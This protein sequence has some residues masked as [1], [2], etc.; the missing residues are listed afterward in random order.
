MAIPIGQPRNFRGGRT[1]YWTGKSWSSTKPNT[2]PN[3]KQNTK[4]KTNTGSS[5]TTK[6]PKNVRGSGAKN[7]TAQN[8][9]SDKV[10]RAIANTAKNAVKGV[11]QAPGR[12][13]RNT[14]KVNQGV[15]Q[16]KEGKRGE[17]VN[18]EARPIGSGR[19]S[20]GKKWA[21]QSMGYQS[22]ESFNQLKDQGQFRAGEIGGS[23]ILSDIGQGI[24]GF[25]RGG[26]EDLLISAITKGMEAYGNAPKPVQQGLNQVGKG[27]QWVDNR[28]EDVSRATNTSRLITDEAV[29]LGAGKALK[30]GGKAVQ[31]GVKSSK[32]A[33][34]TA[35]DK[36]LKAISDV[37]TKPGPGLTSR[38]YRPA[39]MQIKQ[40]KRKGLIKDP[41]GGKNPTKF[42]YANNPNVGSAIPPSM[43]R[44]EAVDG[45][46]YVSQGTP[47]V[48]G[49]FR[50]VGAAG[51]PSNPNSAAAR[52]DAVAGPRIQGGRV[53]PTDRIR[54]Q[55]RSLTTGA[56]RRSDV[57]ARRNSPLAIQAR[58]STR[59]ESNDELIRL[60]EQGLADGMSSEDAARRAH[61]ISTSP[62]RSIPAAERRRMI[63]DGDADDVLGPRVPGNNQNVATDEASRL[64]APR[65]SR[66]GTVRRSDVL[67]G[68]NQPSP[69]RPAGFTA[70][71]ERQAQKARQVRTRLNNMTPGERRRTIE[72]A[73]P[74]LGENATGSRGR[75]LTEPRRGY[76]TGIEGEENA[77]ELPEQLRTARTNQDRFIP[78]REL[79]NRSRR[80][81]R[82]TAIEAREAKEAEAARLRERN[83]QEELAIYRR[84]DQERI[85]SRNRLAG[86]E[87]RQEL[88]VD[89]VRQQP[90][91]EQAA[92]A[93]VNRADRA[94]RNSRVARGRN[95]RNG[96]SLRMNNANRRN[97]MI[98]E[99]PTIR[100]QR[101]GTSR[102]R[103]GS[104]V[105]ATQLDK[106]VDFA[107]SAKRR[108]KIKEVKGQLKR[109]TAKQRGEEL[110]VNK[111]TDMTRRGPINPETGKRERLFTPENRAKALRKKGKEVRDMED[112]DFHEYAEGRYVSAGGKT[113]YQKN[114]SDTEFDQGFRSINED[115]EY[116]S[117]AELKARGIPVRN[118]SKVDQKL[119]MAN[120]GNQQ[121]AILSN[122]KKGEVVT[123]MPIPGSTMMKDGSI[124]VD[125][126]RAKLY[127][128]QTKGALDYLVIDEDTGHSIIK[129]TK[130]GPN[131]W[132]TVKGDIVEFDPEALGA[133]IDRLADKE[134]P[135]RL[136]G[137]RLKNGGGSRA[138][139]KIS[140]K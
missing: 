44:S 61:L 131:K 54:T 36:S 57:N 100:G 3:T 117:D 19:K 129:T 27:A 94:G 17:A 90:V 25:I 7:K 130:V 55:R 104:Y 45:R 118:K 23:R 72:R 123:A 66:P 22:P 101:S 51:A 5:T 92:R 79:Q 68:R 138:Q 71:Q 11:V 124:K 6:K 49:Q 43:R 52:F 88:A 126:Q 59:P 135:R 26:A 137:R 41:K 125:T 136:S 86:N 8:K 119:N 13:A 15:Q 122:M 58:Q 24:D 105:R 84:N 35:T 93:V 14:L 113:T 38:P 85:A 116:R 95:R 31:S 60:Y 103:N 89:R 115:F 65:Q 127:K 140:R 56:I 39:P 64:R 50:S 20:D 102:V 121:G 32:Q 99:R 106:G 139:L 9:P 34:K 28:L 78:N 2:K 81:R 80:S 18:A 114:N 10:N 112:S 98:E 46:Q 83:R 16:L 111:S 47:L 63:R 69:E 1:K 70:G 53:D 4:P 21:G 76:F 133:A 96:D 128:R 33:L 110:K 107:R 132:K 48:D 73:D 74:R 91:G 30:I 120:V 37:V 62:S 97:Q 134:T 29:T 40:A 12:L 77:A 42:D 109:G 108:E 75:N 87:R 82:E 67:S